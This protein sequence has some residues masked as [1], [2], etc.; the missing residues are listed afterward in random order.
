MDTEQFLE[1]LD[2]D[3]PAY[4]D[5]RRIFTSKYL[6]GSSKVTF[7]TMQDGVRNIPLPYLGNMGSDAK[8]PVFD[9]TSGIIFLTQG[10][11]HEL[12][13]GYLCKYHSR[14]EDDSVDVDF[15]AHEYLIAGWGWYITSELS[16][17]R[18]WC[19]EMS[20][21]YKLNAFDKTY[22][23]RINSE[24]IGYRIRRGLQD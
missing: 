24:S 1:T 12:L 22:L 2:E 7:F 17:D 11:T 15:W 19:V 10:M 18:K 6:L 3:N 4:C 21:D 13:L 23:R 20:L 8:T 5:L 9:E 14:V 16:K